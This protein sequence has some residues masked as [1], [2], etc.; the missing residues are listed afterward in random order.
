MFVCALAPALPAGPLA[1]QAPERPYRTEQVAYANA[2][3]STYLTATLTLPP[4]G[5]PHPGVVLLT[6][7]G[8][9]RLV[10]PLTRLGFAV[11]SPERRGFVAVEPLLQA[12]YQDLAG[13]AQ[14]ALDYLGARA[15]VDG[16]RLSL[17]GQADDA[18]AAMLAAGGSTERV[19]LVLLA[20]PGFPGREIFYLE[21]R[22]LAEIQGFRPEAMERLDI[23]L[24]QVADIVLSQSAPYLREF[25]LQSLMAGA[26]VRLPYNAA[27]P[28]DEAQSHFFASPLWHDRLDFEPELV[29][30]RLHAPVLVLFGTE[31]PHTPRDAYLA[32]VR[33]GL[34]V[35][36]AT[37][38]TVCLIQGRT[39]HTFSDEAVDATLRWL[40]DRAGLVGA[41]AAPAE[42][43]ALRGCLQG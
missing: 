15:E 31:D 38:T 16:A 18:P 13:D 36:P 22:W 30:A 28:N 4:G 39:R 5:G 26:D 40:A 33:R 17:I 21:Q 35:A 29:L 7:A 8:T 24:N 37:D 41:G 3:D 34:T 1:G 11:L 32:A 23:Y 27:F 19:P 42:E 43:G 2:Q 25:R 9:D 12:T 14:A 10:D 6:V 20:P